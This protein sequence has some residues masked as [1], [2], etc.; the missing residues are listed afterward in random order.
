MISKVQLVGVYWGTATAYAKTY[1]P[2]FLQDL[3]E[4]SGNR[5]LHGSL[6]RHGTLP[7]RHVSWRPIITTSF[8]PR[9]AAP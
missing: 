9:G 3:A 7:R 1:V 6:L 5:E 2:G 4:L 8:R